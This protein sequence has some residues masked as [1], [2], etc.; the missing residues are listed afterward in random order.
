MQRSSMSN[1]KW[2]RYQTEI[3]KNNFLLNVNLDLELEN[4]QFVEIIYANLYL[5]TYSFEHIMD[6]LFSHDLILFILDFSIKFDEDKDQ[7][8]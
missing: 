6:Y 1:R 8:A 2:R 7:I 3:R 4:S 5:L